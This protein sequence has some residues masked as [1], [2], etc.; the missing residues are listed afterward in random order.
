MDGHQDPD[1]L[2]DPG[3]LARGLGRASPEALH[4]AF[5][6]FFASAGQ[7]KS[8]ALLAALPARFEKGEDVILAAV[9]RGSPPVRL[10]A[11]RRM[12]DFPSTRVVSTLVEIVNRNNFKDRF[13]L[14]EVGEA[15]EALARMDHPRAREFVVEVQERKT[16]LG[17]AYLKEIRKLL[18]TILAGRR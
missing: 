1:A 18:G 4:A 15:L 2:R 14:D 13:L 10:A 9:D 8:E 7:E 16:W 3:L 12:A 17:H 5:A 6:A 11:L